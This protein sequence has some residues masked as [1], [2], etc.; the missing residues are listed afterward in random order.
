MVAFEVQLRNPKLF[1]CPLETVHLLQVLRDL[2]PPQTLPNFRESG[3][4]P[5]KGE[6]TLRAVLFPEGISQFDRAVP[7]LEDSHI[8]QPCYFY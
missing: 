7:F 4:H 1:H 2:L 3:P 6:P 8:E 5:L